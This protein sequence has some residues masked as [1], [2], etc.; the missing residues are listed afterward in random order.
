MAGQFRLQ[1]KSGK[2]E[3]IVKDGY[4]SSTENDS[5][6]HFFRLFGC[7]WWF[8]V[9]KLDRFDVLATGYLRNTGF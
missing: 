2:I 7:W 9:E 3:G 5:L 6:D 4:T 8:E 1:C